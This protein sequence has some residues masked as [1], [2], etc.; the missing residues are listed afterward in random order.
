MRFPADH[1]DAR[2]PSHPPSDRRSSAGIA[3]G[4][5]TPIGRAL[6]GNWS[7]M[8]RNHIEG[9]ACGIFLGGACT[10]IPLILQTNVSY[11]LQLTSCLLA[12]GIG[13][14]ANIAF[15]TTWKR[16]GSYRDELRITFQRHSQIIRN[17]RRSNEAWREAAVEW[18]IGSLTQ[19]GSGA[20]AARAPRGKTSRHHPLGAEGGTVIDFPGR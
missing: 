12:T 14:V 3:A 20:E 4:R 15:W 2:I 13:I 16:C 1:S 5:P 11:G 10:A 19:F 9:W 7:E 6:F 8:E 17:L 18:R